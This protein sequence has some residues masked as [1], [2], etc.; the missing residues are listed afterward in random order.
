MKKS[1]IIDESIRQEVLIQFNKQQAYKASAELLILESEKAA[2]K[3][4]HSI[5]LNH[6]ELEGC[7]WQLD[8]ASWICTYEKQA[9]TR[10]GENVIDPEL[11]E[12]H[13]PPALEG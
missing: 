10:E 6:P 3:L 8:F 1:L 11:C 2:I 5:Y 12:V 7:E 9:M 13:T 4:W